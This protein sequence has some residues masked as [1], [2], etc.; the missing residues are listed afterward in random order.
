MKT[1]VK[2]ILLTVALFGCEEKIENGKI[3]DNYI[4]EAKKFIGNFYGRLEGH[5]IRLNIF[6]DSQ[7]RLIINSFN[8]DDRKQLL[9]GCNSKIGLLESVSISS[10]DNTLRWAQFEFDSKNCG[11]PLS[12]LT[13]KPTNENI[14]SLSLA[15]KVHIV[16][17]HTVCRRNGKYG[18]TCTSTPS[19]TV[20]DETISGDFK[21][22]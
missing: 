22:Y 2:V 3:P 21:R 8:D 6:L 13:V 5:V 19:R 16:P 15:K 4:G 17:G 18:R 12:G 10:N 14:L 7:N 11:L 9:P 1:I 20:V